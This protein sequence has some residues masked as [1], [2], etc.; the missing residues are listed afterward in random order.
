MAGTLLWAPNIAETYRHEVIEKFVRATA[1]RL[2]RE[3]KSV[4]CR[5]LENRDLVIMFYTGQIPK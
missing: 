4:G 5:P 1:E 3:C 2:D